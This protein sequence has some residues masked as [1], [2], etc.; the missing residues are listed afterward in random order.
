MLFLA[1]LLLQANFGQVWQAHHRRR[2][3]YDG[4]L[5][6]GTSTGGQHIHKSLRHDTPTQEI[7]GQIQRSTA[8]GHV[9][10]RSLGQIRA[11]RHDQ[12]HQRRERFEDDRVGD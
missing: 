6:W 5:C 11:A 3:V 10:V 4:V 9:H 7:P 12:Q 1:P 8:N 2:Y